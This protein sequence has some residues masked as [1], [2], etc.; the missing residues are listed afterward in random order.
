M[1]QP[2]TPRIIAVCLVIPVIL[3]LFIMNSSRSG[4][5]T[6]NDPLATAIP[7]YSRI[8]Q[9][10]T[11]K[12]T[13]QISNPN[14]LTELV[15]SPEYRN[16]INVEMLKDIAVPN[17]T[18]AYPKDWPILARLPLGKSASQDITLNEVQTYQYYDMKRS[19]KF[20]ARTT[21]VYAASFTFKGEQLKAETIG[22]AMFVNFPGWSIY[23]NGSDTRKKGGTVATSNNRSNDIVGNG[24]VLYLPT[25]QPDIFHLI[26]T[27]YSEDKPI[28]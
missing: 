28:Q 21:Y 22:T 4:N 5:K 6:T 11:Q 15:S 7:R 24:F 23:S 10:T 26:M 27:I 17:A 16:A 9:V 13:P 8:H 3:I 20:A 25:D 1:N 19:S 18:I 12:T 2:N 14:S